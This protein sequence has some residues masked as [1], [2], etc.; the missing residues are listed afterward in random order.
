MSSRISA[1]L[2]QKRA[3]LAEIRRQKEQRQKRIRDLSSNRVA[4]TTREDVDSL[5]SSLVG[6]SAMP[7]R[8]LASGGDGTTPTTAGRLGIRERGMSDIGAAPVYPSIAEA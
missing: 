5:V 7:R 8:P 6:E 1:E 3:R 2:E 4:V